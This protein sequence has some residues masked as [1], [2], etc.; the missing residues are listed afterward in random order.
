MYSP[1]EII[2]DLDT[3]KPVRLGNDVWNT[4]S[5]PKNHTHF[6]KPTGRFWQGLSEYMVFCPK[7]LIEAK[8]LLR[9]NEIVPAP[10][11]SMVTELPCA[12]VDFNWVKHKISRFVDDLKIEQVR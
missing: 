12:T 8:K 10:K 2:F 3:K 11:D 5:Y 4:A 6:I 7:S 1:G 9:Y